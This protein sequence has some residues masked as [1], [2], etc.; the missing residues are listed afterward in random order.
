LALAAGNRIQLIDVRPPG[1]AEL[2]FR[3]GVARFNA[4]WH[5]EQAQRSEEARDWY[6]AV[7]HW[8][9][10]AQLPSDPG[11]R[12]WQK[13]ETACARLGDWRPALA[14]CDR[15]LRRDATLG[16]IYFRRA[17]V[18]A[19]LLQFHEAAADQLVGLV[20]LARNPL[21]WP[22]LAAEAAAEGDDHAE[23]GNW[24][25]ASRAF[26]DA[27]RW[28]PTYSEY[29][30]R[31]AWSQLAG[32]KRVAF[33]TTCR[34]LY[35]Q[36]RP[37]ADVG[38]TYRLMAH[39]GFDLAPGPSLLRGL[40][41][42]AAQALLDNQRRASDMAIVWTACLAPDSG[43]PAA[44]LVRLAQRRVEAQPN[45]WGVLE[46]LGAAEYRAGNYEQ[47]AKILERAVKRHGAGGTNWMKL[48]L[49]LACHKLE[50]PATARDWFEK[51]VLPK[52]A[53]WQE[54]LLFHQLR[55]EASALLK[56]PAGPKR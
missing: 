48:F 35:S 21:G 41:Q 54:R 38:R 11:K 36:R 46:N 7:F 42:P 56:L 22:E 18:R 17:R 47:A 8:E 15:L 6:A 34:A 1:K 44:E 32:G 37:P 12:Y 13:L 45:L 31:L 52:G 16:P 30:F 39:L 49:A 53:D 5:E 20:L 10:L 51:A 26:A 55:A 23:R 4:A 27:A 2:S 40:G 25:E 19:H 9:R 3:A 29:R 14:V 33:R 24:G 43:L 28:Q 50:Q